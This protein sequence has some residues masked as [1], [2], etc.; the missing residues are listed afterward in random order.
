MKLV[1]QRVSRAAVHVGGE[2]VA[3]IRAGALVLAGAARND[4]LEDARYLAKKTSQLR[5]YDDGDGRLNLS[6]DPDESAFLVV[7]Q[8]TLY[9][10]CE[11]GNRPSFI[12]AA[13]SDEGRLLYDEYIRTLQS[14]GHEVHCGR[15]QEHMHVELENDGPVT[16]ILESRGRVSA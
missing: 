13:G 10:N 15:F 1:I 4:T 7:S 11:K 12:E 6:I 2:C 14:L 8:F 16:L 5:M 3:R 9:G